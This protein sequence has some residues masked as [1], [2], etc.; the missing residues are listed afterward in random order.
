MSDD[1]TSRVLAAIAQLGGQVAQ[2]GGDMTQLRGDMT[3]LSGDMTQLRGDMTQLSGDMTQLRTDVTQLRTDM[4]QL[5][6][7]MTQL[8]TDMVDR[9]DRL[10]VDMMERM[11]RLQN[12]FSSMQQDITVNFA[13]SDRADRMVR[14]ATD[15]TRALADQVSAM[16]RQIRVLTVR[17]DEIDRRG[18]GHAKQG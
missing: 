5:R 10:R 13:A 16:V 11:D 6:T 14:H 18:N 1:P 15:E 17:V 4:T 3:Q 8:R 2:L 9:T 12:A 7:D